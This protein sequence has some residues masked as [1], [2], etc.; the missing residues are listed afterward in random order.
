MKKLIRKLIVVCTT[1]IMITV[2]I[3]SSVTAAYFPPSD[4]YDY[5]YEYGGNLPTARKDVTG[6][7]YRYYNGRDQRRLWSFTRGIW[8]ESSWSYI[9]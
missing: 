1:S 4:E 2:A 8:L 5:S 9:N 3:T 7:I 6:Y